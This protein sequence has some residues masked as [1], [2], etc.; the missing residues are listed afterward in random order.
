MR[1]DG[2]S[3][4]ALMMEGL[5]IHQKWC[6]LQNFDFLIMH[7]I[8]YL[9]DGG[10]IFKFSYAVHMEPNN[11]VLPVTLGV[12][13]VILEEDVD[14][15]LYGHGITGVDEGSIWYGFIGEEGAFDLED[16]V[17]SRDKELVVVPLVLLR[18]LHKNI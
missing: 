9:E 3:R 4:I 5:S 6:E 8:F 14:E 11:N 2:Q 16:A 18:E 13:F 17:A 15:I 7:L 12:Y 10:V 1:G